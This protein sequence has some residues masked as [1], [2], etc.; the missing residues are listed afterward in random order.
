VDT[1]TRNKLILDHLKYED[2]YTFKYTKKF[3]CVVPSDEIRSMVL[4]SIV[5]L[6]HRF[7]ETRGF[8]F[9]TLLDLLLDMRCLLV[10]E[11]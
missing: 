11:L 5:T 8:K 4:E 10:F 3:K 1:K 9:I 6:A 2:Y 7:D